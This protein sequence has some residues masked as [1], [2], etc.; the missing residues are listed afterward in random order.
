MILNQT[1]FIKC[2]DYFT[3]FYESLHNKVIPMFV[4]IQRVYAKKYKLKFVPRILQQQ[5]HKFFESSKFDINQ[6]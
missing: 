3:K 5:L 6:I 1:K 4:Y 2:K